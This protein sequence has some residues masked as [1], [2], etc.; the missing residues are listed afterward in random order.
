MNM[1]GT[2]LLDPTVV[3]DAEP[4]VVP[5]PAWDTPSAGPHYSATPAV[6]VAGSTRLRDALWGNAFAC[7]RR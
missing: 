3:R 6:L 4:G 5:L 2:T 7:S 1:D